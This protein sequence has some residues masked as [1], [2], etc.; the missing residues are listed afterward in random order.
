[1]AAQTTLPYATS[2]PADSHLMEAADRIQ[3]EIAAVGCR[4][5]AMD[6]K[7]SDLTVASTSIRADITGFWETVADLD[8]RLTTVEDWVA[9]LS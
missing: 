8:Q 5:E 9:S 4:L 6:S 2:L 7:I 3:Q 1:M